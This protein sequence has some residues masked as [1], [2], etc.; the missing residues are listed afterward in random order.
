MIKRI[1]IVA[2]TLT[3]AFSILFISVFRSASVKYSFSGKS[4]NNGDIYVAEKSEDLVG[5]SGSA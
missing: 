2:V 3:F 5:L 1:L 4:T